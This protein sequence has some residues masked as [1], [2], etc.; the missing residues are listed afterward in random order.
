M[1]IKNQFKLFLIVFQLF[2]PLI[3][4]GDHVIG[5]D[6]SYEC[7]GQGS[8]PNSRIYK[9]N[10]SQYY[11]CDGWELDP[12]LNIRKWK[13]NQPLGIFFIRLDTVILVEE[14][15]YPCLE[16]PP[17]LCFEKRI[18]SSEIEFPISDSTYIISFQDCC[19]S[20]GINNI[21]DSEYV[22]SIH[23]IEIIPSAQSFC[24]NSPI[25]DELPPLVLCANETVEFS[26]AAIDV[27]GDQLIYEFCAPLNYDTPSP[28]IPTPPPF[29]NNVPFLFPNFSPSNPLGEGMLIINPN[30]GALSGSVEIAGKF[31]VGICVSDYRN[32]ELLGTTQRDIQLNVVA[33]EPSVFA[34]IE[35][36][37]VSNGGT[38]IINSCGEKNINFN[39]VSYPID[40]IE[41]VNWIFNNGFGMDT[42]TT[43]DANVTFQDFGEY[44]G[45]MILNPNNLCPDSVE[46]LINIVDKVSSDFAAVYDT[47]SS[48]PVQF[49]NQSFA[50]G[51]DILSWQWDFGDGTT[52][53]M[54]NPSKIYEVPDSFYVNLVSIDTFNCRDSIEKIIDWR[55]APSAIIIAP[56]FSEGCVP[57]SVSFDN[58]S[59]PIDSTYE[60]NW[61]FGDNLGF[62][63]DL[64]PNYVFQSEGD[65]SVFVSA[66]S[67]LGCYID[68]SFH[69]LITVDRKPIANFSYQVE[70]LGNERYEISLL[71]HSQ[72]SVRWDWFFNDMDSSYMQE[73]TYVF[74]DTGFHKVQLITTDIYD[75]KDSLTKIIDIAPQDT[76]FLPNAFTPNYDGKNDTFQGV[77]VFDGIRKFN[78]KIW[79]RYGGLIF[80]TTNPKTGWNGEFMNSG[81]GFPSGVYTCMVSYT[82]AREGEVKTIKSSFVLVR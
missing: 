67:P 35:A 76:Y 48:G 12:G 50:E 9:I 26:Q 79:D 44:S 20:I 37:T 53:V 64:S 63:R 38:F 72:R 18:Y 62:S 61:D 54:K 22:G 43:W 49:E 66:T 39:N 13:S 70:N 8:T 58:L 28:V 4:V 32:G 25:F 75:C 23:F 30:T 6:M 27:D 71:D 52:S 73:P 19:R 74:S 33:C 5:A 45:M 14:P 34:E 17:G 80:Q 59:W 24:N 56:N 51:R 47:C 42:S 68:T 65:F 69:N 78:L 46:I 3:A 16:L 21:V 29:I 2:N 1:E 77:G 36:S 7:L 81:K 60:I 10:Y 57:L 31:I 40:N 41:T 55:P 15:N 11:R 82:T